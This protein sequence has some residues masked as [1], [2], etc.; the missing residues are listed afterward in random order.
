MKSCKWTP[1][2]LCVKMKLLEQEKTQEWLCNEIRNRYGLFADSSYMYKI[3]TGQRA[4]Q[5]LVGAIC[6]ILQI[7]ADDAGRRATNGGH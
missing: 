2:G 7:Q 4:P 6:E 3:L 1:F 5:R